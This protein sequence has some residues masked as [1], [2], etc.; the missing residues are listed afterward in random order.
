MVHFGNMFVKCKIRN[1]ESHTATCEM[2]APIKH[3]EIF[4]AQE[5]LDI[6]FEASDA[7]SGQLISLLR[8]L[9]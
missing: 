1:L 8:C 9:T 4:T 3:R 2:S 6:L 5:D 7:D